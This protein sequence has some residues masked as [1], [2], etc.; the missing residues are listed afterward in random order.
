VENLDNIITI[1]K[2]WPDDPFFNC[3]PNNTMKDYLKVERYL[4]Y[5]NY[6]L[7]EES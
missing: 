2:I 7:I 3:M 5:D 4:A 6:E 1:V